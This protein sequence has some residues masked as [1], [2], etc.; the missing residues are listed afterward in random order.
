M[1]SADASTLAATVLGRFEG[2]VAQAEQPFVLGLSGLQGSGKSTLA[3]ALVDAARERGWAAVALSLDDVYLTRAERAVLAVEVHP[4]LRT[5]GVPGTHDLALLASTLDALAKASPG[6]PV[7]IPRF[8]KGRDD[9][10]EPALW[11]AIAE[12]PKLVVLE[13]WCLGVEPAVDPADLTE[14]MNALERCEDPDGRWRRWVDARLAEYLPVW[15]RIDA[16]T[17][18]RAPSWDVVATWRA[19]AEK[20]LRERGEPGAMDDAALSRFLQHYERI[21]RRALE[22]LEQKA[23]LTIHLDKS[24]RATNL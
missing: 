15:K 14:P 3:A 13:G 2:A 11:P 19:E 1:E 20:P 10:R 17:L 8:D 12:P 23:G 5:R 7:A 9:R 18:L 16:L 6:K 24:R 4:L 21:S 22:T